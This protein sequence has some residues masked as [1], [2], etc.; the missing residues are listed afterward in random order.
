MKYVKESPVDWTEDKR[1]S[2]IQQRNFICTQINRLKYQMFASIEGSLS[3]AGCRVNRH[4]YKQAHLEVIK[5]ITKLI[6]AG[7]QLEQ[8]ADSFDQFKDDFTYEPPLVLLGQG[9]YARPVWEGDQ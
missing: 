9:E 8:L 2:A 4:Q 7:E 6:E 5:A 1:K 3:V